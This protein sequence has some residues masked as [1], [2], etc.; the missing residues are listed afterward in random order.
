MTTPARAATVTLAAE[1]WLRIEQALHAA[2]A[3]LHRTGNGDQARRYQHTREL[4]QHVIERW[5]VKA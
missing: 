4:I 1:H 2:A 5:E 3:N